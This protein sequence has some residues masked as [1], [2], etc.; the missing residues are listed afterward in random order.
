M[1]R[2]LAIAMAGDR[3]FVT[4]RRTLRRVAE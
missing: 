4:F 2:R 3:H 1:D